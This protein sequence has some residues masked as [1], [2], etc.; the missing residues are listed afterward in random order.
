[1]FG[2]FFKYEDFKTGQ[3]VEFESS[4]YQKKRSDPIFHANFKKYY[5]TFD[6]RIIECPPFSAALKPVTGRR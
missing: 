6:R 4:F 1:M 5:F 2:Q 3:A